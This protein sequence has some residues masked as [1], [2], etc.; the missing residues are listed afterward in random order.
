MDKSSSAK[1]HVPEQVSKDVKEPDQRSQM[2][3]NWINK[4]PV[5]NP[6]RRSS[7]CTLF[8]QGN[9][10]VSQDKE[11]T[12]LPRNRTSVVSIRPLRQLTLRARGGWRFSASLQHVIFARSP[13]PRE[14]ESE[15]HPLSISQH[16]G[17]GLIGHGDMAE[18]V[19]R[20]G[21]EW[22]RSLNE[23]CFFG[24][25]GKDTKKKR[26][27]GSWDWVNEVRMMHS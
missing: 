11:G 21:E 24:L 18:L 25:S 16:S 5:R 27:R 12:A 10:F 23:I 17:L 9:R 2:G 1:I 14:S 19:S 8:K 6:F 7:S 13:R 15:L 20:E 3:R 4:T 26:F 22:E